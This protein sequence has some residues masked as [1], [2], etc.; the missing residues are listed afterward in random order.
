MD[1]ALT[2][3]E[4]RVLVA[5]AP[6]KRLAADPDAA[7]LPRTP[8]APNPEPER[9][10][11]L[12]QRQPWRKPGEP[13]LMGVFVHVPGKRLHAVEDGLGDLRRRGV[14]GG[15]LDVLLLAKVHAD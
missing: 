13:R 12:H 10:A 8:R 3:H 2:P 7:A 6:G 14:E 9:P 4:R 15:K 1:E 5:L 11:Q